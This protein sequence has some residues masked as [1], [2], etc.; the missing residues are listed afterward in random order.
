M[1]ILIHCAILFGFNYH[2]VKFRQILFAF[3]FLALLKSYRDILIKLTIR[4]TMK[5]RKVKSNKQEYEQSYS[6]KLRWHNLSIV[7]KKKVIKSIHKQ[8][9]LY[10][11]TE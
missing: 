5:I 1:F 2:K 7:T 3:I 10:C 11:H 8:K 4:I 9:I 6:K